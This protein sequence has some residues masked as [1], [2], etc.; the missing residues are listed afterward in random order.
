ML[1]D[2]NVL[3]TG[4]QLGCIMEQKTAGNA[5]A[6]LAQI[7]T[8]Q[9]VTH[10]P[11]S[12]TVT[13]RSSHRRELQDNVVWLQCKTDH[14][15]TLEQTSLSKKRGGQIKGCRI[16]VILCTVK[17]SPPSSS[18]SSVSMATRNANLQFGK[19]EIVARNRAGVKNEN[20][21]QKP[22]KQ[23]KVAH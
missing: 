12:A 18:N 3:P 6:E 7:F 22:N 11:V 9:E 19:E 16:S 23:I 10:L 1:L 17:I 21:N 4:K 15:A 2:V 20:Q 14:G 13:G 5:E 8:S